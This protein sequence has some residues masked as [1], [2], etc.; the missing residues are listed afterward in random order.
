M[1]GNISDLLG[2]ERAEAVR[3][4][5]L[6]D[7]AALDNDRLGRR[8]AAA[9]HQQPWRAGFEAEAAKVR[10]GFRAACGI[11]SDI[12]D[13][14]LLLAAPT[15]YPVDGHADLASAATGTVGAP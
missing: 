8:L 2:A 15:P 9:L 1:K 10:A 6:T 13:S 11:D 3:Q 7:L 12:A 4:E 14:E 5:V